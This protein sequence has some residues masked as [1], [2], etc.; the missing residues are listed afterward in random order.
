MADKG[1]HVPAEQPQTPPGQGHVELPSAIADFKGSFVRNGLPEAAT[2]RAVPLRRAKTSQWV[3]YFRDGWDDIGIW[4]SAFIEFVA[5]LSLCYT[6]GLIDT[7]IMNFNTSQLPAYAG[8]SNIFL[9][10]LFIMGAGPGSGGH[11]N[12]LITLATVFTGLTGF[13]RGILYLIAQTVGGA[14]AG[15][16]LRGSFGRERTV[17]YKG[18]GCFISP[19][20]VSS[21]EAFLIE[22][23]CSFVLLFLA[24]GVGLDPRQRVLFGMFAGPLAVGC[25]LGLVSFASAGLVPGYTGASMN[26][27]RCFAFAVARAEFSSQWVWWVGPLAGSILHS[28]VWWIAPPYHSGPVPAGS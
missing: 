17:K 3:A 25:S 16:L 23:M 15:G 7:T 6:S 22:T 14:L 10:T 21:G 4:K 1:V 5:T 24:F 2:A 18:G 27:A 13:S 20:T 12:P 11:V 19:G 28:A 9:L 8:V 26:P